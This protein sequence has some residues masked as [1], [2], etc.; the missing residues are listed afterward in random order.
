MKQNNLYC[1]SLLLLFYG[2]PVLAE[3]LRS[4]LISFDKQTIVVEN[5]AQLYQALK[6]ANKTGHTLIQLKKGQYLLKRPLIIK[7][8]GIFIQGVSSDRNQVIIKG[9]GMKGGITH[10]FLVKNDDFIVADLT[11]GWVKYHAIQIQGEKGVKNTTISNIQFFDTGQQMLKISGGAEKLHRSEGGLVEW[12]SFIFST[13]YAAQGYTGG[14]DAHNALNWVIKNNYFEGIRSPDNSLA[15]HAIHFWNSSENTLVENNIIVNSDRGIGFGLG[16]KGHKAGIIRNNMIHTNRDVG[17]G[18]ESSPR[19]KIYHNSVFT[20]NYMNSI[21]YRFSSTNNVLISNNLVNKRIQSRNGS[22]ALII[23]NIDYAN[24]K[25]FLDAKKGNLRL[26][27]GLSNVIDQ[28][29][30]IEGGDQDIDC[31]QRT[32]SH[33]VDIGAAEYQ[34]EIDKHIHI[35]QPSEMTRTLDEFGILGQQVTQYIKKNILSG[36]HLKYYLL[37]LILFIE[38]LFIIVMLIYIIKTIRKKS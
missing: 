38:Q 28:G 29:K 9:K 24:E 10:I 25:W 22:Q 14:I 13:G 20:E 33:R 6:R 7:A 12:S 35:D 36:T 19:T 11:M 3:C 5:V 23:D 4:P 34:G 18:I 30:M 15:E 27:V 37:G 31:R 16:K 8:K 32:S 2:M 1:F 17:I 26:R 21:E